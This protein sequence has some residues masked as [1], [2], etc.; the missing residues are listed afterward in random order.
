M[1]QTRLILTNVPAGEVAA[2][3]AN[4]LVNEHLAACVNILPG[5]SSVYRW[6]G[7][8]ENSAEELL[9]IKTKAALVPT[10]FERVK[11]MHPYDVPELIEIIPE[12]VE[13]SYLQWLLKETLPAQK[14]STQ[15]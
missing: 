11:A 15:V 10:V 2:A 14:P 4:A 7:K 5:I 8:L 3:I 13:N 1:K 9:L 12:S 6:Q